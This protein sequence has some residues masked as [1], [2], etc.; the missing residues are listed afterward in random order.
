MSGGSKFCTLDISDDLSKSGT[1][2]S[3]EKKEQERLN[4]L[5]VSLMCHSVLHRILPLPSIVT[6]N[7]IAYV[8]I[9]LWPVA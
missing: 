4:E 3:N 8:S 1:S 2:C 5:E 6:A 9:N 7:T